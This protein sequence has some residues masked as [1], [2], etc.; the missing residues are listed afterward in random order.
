MQLDRIWRD[1]GLAVREVEER[2]PCHS[3]SSAQLYVTSG[4]AHLTPPQRRGVAGAVGCRGFADHV[5]AALLQLDVQVA[6]VLRTHQHHRGDN[7]EDPVLEGQPLS[8]RWDGA[9]L[10]MR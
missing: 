8:G 5:V 1:P 2:D 3:S 9:G 4:D 10:V 6:V 7:R